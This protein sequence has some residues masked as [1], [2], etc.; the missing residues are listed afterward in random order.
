MI[1][2]FAIGLCVVLA[3]GGIVLTV[4]VVRQPPRGPTRHTLSH[5]SSL[6]T[7]DPGMTVWGRITS[8]RE[9][10]V[11]PDGSGRIEERN[12][13]VTFPSDA[14]QKEW[15]A[16][17]SPRLPGMSRTFKSGE[18]A[19]VRLDEV[20]RDPTRLRESLTADSPSS[21]TILRRIVLILYENVPPV[22]LTATIV[23]VLRDFPGI[24][25]KENGPLIT[26]RG[27]DESPGRRSEST[28]VIDA[29]SGQ[30]VSERRRALTAVPGLSA[31]PPIVMLERTVDDT[32]LIAP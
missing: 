7:F 23:S 25:V 19:Y 9:I 6:M 3:I 32:G 13:P 5:G 12:D 27:T 2:K 28:V 22:E 16:I 1:G 26:F 10:W 8:V 18:L 31:D 24:E 21:T 15:I 20:P 30:L 17:G 14:E 29:T 4:L 11:A